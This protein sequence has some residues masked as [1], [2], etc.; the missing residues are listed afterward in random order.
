MASNQ[1]Y[2]GY[3]GP[4]QGE[5]LNNSQFMIDQATA[6]VNVMHPVKVIAVYPGNNANVPT[7]VDVQPMI[8]QVDP[9]GNR[10]PHGTI[11]GVPAARMHAGGNALLLDPVIGDVGMMHVADRDASS[12]F[13]NGGAQSPPGSSRRHDMADGF[14]HGGLYTAKPTNFVDLRG[15]NMALTTQGNI[16]H[17]AQGDITLSAQGSVNMGSSSNNT[18]IKSP[19]GKFLLLGGD[20]TGDYEFVQTVAGPSSVVKA[21]L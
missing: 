12:L 20:G 7:T 9:Q 18:V 10:T 21:K 17:T 2:P 16:T 11:Y 3:F 4:P 5:E 14:Y 13:A 6:R 8:D 15:G 19:P 1:G